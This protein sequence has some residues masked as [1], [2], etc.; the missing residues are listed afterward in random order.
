MFDH[1]GPKELKEWAATAHNS[2][3]QNR[4]RI[5]HTFFMVGESVFSS[6]LEWEDQSRVQGWKNAKF[7][8]VARC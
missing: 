2:C 5:S 8:T 6:V 7:P 3:L 1:R 4:R